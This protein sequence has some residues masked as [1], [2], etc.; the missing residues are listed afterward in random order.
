MAM[1]DARKRLDLP[2]RDLRLKGSSPGRRRRRPDDSQDAFSW[3]VRRSGL[4][5]TSSEC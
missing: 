3:T 4:A 1:P 2:V 5:A